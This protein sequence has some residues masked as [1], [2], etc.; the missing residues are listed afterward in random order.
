MKIK[1]VEGVK[2]KHGETMCP[3]INLPFYSCIDE[4]QSTLNTSMTIKYDKIF[5]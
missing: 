5:R 3:V 4:N 2:A 1:L